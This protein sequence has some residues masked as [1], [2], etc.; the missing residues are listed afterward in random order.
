MNSTI[1]VL[2]LRRPKIDYIS[3]PVC[4]ALFSSSSFPV[5]V[6]NPLTPQS[7]PTGLILGGSG[8][9]L[10]SWN[11]YPGALCYSV[12]KSVDPDN[13]FGQYVIIAECIPENQFD[14]TGFGPGFFRVS[15]VTLDGET[16]LSLP[17]FVGGGGGGFT[18]PSFTG[19]APV[20]PVIG[21]EGEPATLGPVPFDAGAGA[22]ALNFEWYKDGVFFEDTTFTTS[23]TLIIPSFEND[24]AGLY[25]LNITTEFQDC[26]IESEDIGLTTDFWRLEW[27][28]NQEAGTAVFFKSLEE[29]TFVLSLFQAENPNPGA[30]SFGDYTGSFT[31]SGPER[32]CHLHLEVAFT[33]GEVQGQAIKI[34]VGGVTVLE[35]PNEETTVDG[36]YEYDFVI[37]ASVDALVTLNL[38][39][40]V[41]SLPPNVARQGAWSGI[42]TAE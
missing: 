11:T 25:F 23:N 20:N 7:Y 32:N 1:D 2:F 27:V 22:G 13:A 28:T 19:P 4:E 33:P 3:P 17:I 41:Q 21:T 9:F 40:H 39:M 36:I 34:D 38:F 42:L 10:L 26:S 15:A 31:Y 24:D 18:C 5:I 16:P 6:L 35:L 37:P 29:S 30:N 14:L 12:Y 8:G